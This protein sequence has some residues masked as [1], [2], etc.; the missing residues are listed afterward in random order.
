MLYSCRMWSTTQLN[1]PPPTPPQPLTTTH[2]LYI[3]CIYFGKGGGEEVREKAEGQQYKRGVENTNT[4]DCI[5]SLCPSNLITVSPLP[6]LPP[7]Q[8]QST[9]YSDSVLLGGFGGDVELVWRPYSACK[10]LNTLFLARFRTYAK[11]LYH[12]KQ[13]P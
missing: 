5:S 10:E 2:C 7:S 6:P 9:V 13:K 11:L 1:T 3:L 12:P 8:N 4:T